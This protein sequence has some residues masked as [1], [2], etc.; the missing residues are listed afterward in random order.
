MNRAAWGR[1]SIA[2]GLFVF[3]VVPLQAESAG[4][5][6]LFVL[7]GQSNMKHVDPEVSF[8]PSLKKAFPNDEILVVK[9]AH[10][11]EPIRRWYR[12]WKPESGEVAKGT[13]VGDIYDKLIKQVE[14]TLRG[15]PAPES[16]TF[17]WMQGKPTLPH[18]IWPMFM[19]KAS[20]ASSPRSGTTCSV[21]I[22]W[23]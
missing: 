4:K 8:T 20:R 16:V 23:W 5:T 21:P 2:A 10:S 19:R 14:E 15:R 1:L 12:D 6:R 22:A 7:S 11:G 18:P 17:V 13:L 3:S 9:V